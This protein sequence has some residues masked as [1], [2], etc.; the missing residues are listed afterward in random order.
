MIRDENNFI[1]TID[2]LSPEPLVDDEGWRGMDIRFATGEMTGSE[3][4][5][6]WRT[7]FPP[8]M[9]HERHR[10]PHATEFL[11]VIAG[12]AALGAGA[13]ET[14]ANPGTLQIIPPG[15]VHWLRN[16]DADRPVEVVG[17]YVGA[18]SLEKAGY[19]FVG[20]ITDEFR[21]VT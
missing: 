6:F 16:L 15:K 12:R 18:P 2:E 11:Y 5:C 13:A 8:G 19:V 20:A 3:T 4:L 21:T 17:G 14:V 9:A 7:L 10:H 1:T